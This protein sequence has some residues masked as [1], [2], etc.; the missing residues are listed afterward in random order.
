MWPLK[1][2]TPKTQVIPE[3]VLNLEPFVN[4][5]KFETQT[6]QI[7]AKYLVN[8]RQIRAVHSDFSMGGGGFVPP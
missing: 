7:L 3:M 6:G 1:D 2:L 5:L 8:I 4:P